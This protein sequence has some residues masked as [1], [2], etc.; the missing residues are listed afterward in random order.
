MQRL[1]LYLKRRADLTRH[2]FFA[3]WLGH[4]SALAT[5]LPGLRRHIISLAADEPEGPF[6]GMAE[7]WFDDLAAA[8]AA[9][10]SAV[11]QSARADADAHVARRE[12]LPLTEHMIIDHPTPPRFKFAAGSSA[13]RT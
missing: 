1:V 11:G 4:H 10:A 13:A 7:L 8:K 2:V 6:D 12:R 9:C 5:Q 3:W